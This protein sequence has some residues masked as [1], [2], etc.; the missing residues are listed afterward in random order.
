L[1]QILRSKEVNK[2]IK[3]HKWKYFI[4]VQSILLQKVG[5]LADVVGALPKYQNNA[6]HKAR[7]VVPSYDTKF[8]KKM[9]LKVFILGHVKLGSFNFPFHILKEK[10]IF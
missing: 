4:S 2:T 5:G 9:I 7:V 3:F 10:K 6:G 8:I 1:N